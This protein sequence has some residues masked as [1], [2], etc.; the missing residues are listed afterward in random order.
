MLAD[1]IGFPAML[2]RTCAKSISKSFLSITSSRLTFL[3]SWEKTLDQ[4]W[5]YRGK[6][7]CKLVS[8]LVSGLDQ[9]THGHNSAH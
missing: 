2:K 1:V 7:Y 4:N 5:E 8:V 3:V 6:K 9:E